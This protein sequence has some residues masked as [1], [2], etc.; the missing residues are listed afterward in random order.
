MKS[1]SILKSKQS[2]KF[3]ISAKR[4]IYLFL[5]FFA[6]ISFLFT[7]NSFAQTTTGG[8][9]GAFSTESAGFGGL[10]SETGQ[11]NAG[12]DSGNAAGGGGGGAGISGGSGGYSGAGNLIVGGTGGAAYGGS[13][14]NGAPCNPGAGECN[15]QGGGGGGGGGAGL[16][17][18]AVTTV[19][20]GT[21]QGGNG[22]S[23]GYTENTA[24][25]VGGGGG[26]GGAGGFGLIA[27]SSAVTNSGSI[28]GGTG[29]A[30]GGTIGTSN[31]GNG[32]S[33]GDGG[34][35]VYLSGSSSLNNSGTITGGAGGAQGVAAGTGIN[36]ASGRIGYGVY[37]SSNASVG[38][39]TNSGSIASNSYA[40][41]TGTNAYVGEISNTSSGTIGNGTGSAIGIFTNSVVGSLNNAGTIDGSF[42][43]WVEG[44][45]TISNL[46]NTGII[47][48]YYG[49]STD[50]G[51][52]IS[53]LTNG[54]SSNSTA[55]ISA[56]YVG[57]LIGTLNNYAVIGGASDG[58]ISVYAGGS[59]NVLN[60]YSTGVIQGY[61]G[62]AAI[63]IGGAFGDPSTTGTIATIN[64]QG[65]I[66]GG[67]NATGIVIESLGNLGALNNLSGGIIQGNRADGLENYGTIANL[68]NAGLIRSFGS[69]GRYGVVNSGT[70][71]YLNNSGGGTIRGLNIGL[72]NNAGGS[73]ATLLNASGASIE[74]AIGLSNAGN[75]GALTNLGEITGSSVASF[76]GIYNTGTITTLNNSQASLIYSGT[77][78]TNYN[79]IINSISSFGKLAVTSASGSTSFGIYSGSTLAKSTYSS[80][81]SGVTSS[82]LTGAK[83]GNYNGFTWSLS[84]SSGTIWDLIV[85]GASTA[86]TQ[87]S[88]VN[89]SQ[90]LQGAYALQNSVLANSFSY[91]CNVFGANNVCVSAG[92]RNT[93]VQAAN[94]LNNTS[95]LLIAAYRL[96]PNYRIGAYADQNLSV[97][98]PGGTVNLGNNT[99]LIGLFGAWNQRLDGTGAEVKVSAAYGQKSATVTRAAVV[100]S[101]PGSGSSNLV[102]QGAQITAKYGFRIKNNV[103]VS[104]Y[105]GVRYTQNNMGGYT[106]GTSSSV[107]A[108][109]TYSALNTNATTALAGVGGSYRVIPAVTTFASAGVETDT[110][111][112]NGT[113]SATGITGLTPINFNANPVK[114][115]PTATLGA[116]YDIE[117]NQRFGVTGIYRQEAY[118]AVS[119]TTVMAT[120]TIGL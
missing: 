15:G 71:T 9:G 41:T 104:P 91:D 69:G 44:N 2:N 90:A 43:I 111:T 28:S 86:D 10:D 96:N 3:S 13:G 6:A 107:T 94:G 73:I 8:N 75:I 84:N 25:G 80:V 59:V 61:S 101:E 113:Y 106:E 56:I 45:S 1:L 7:G 117:K 64:N 116:Y 95:A 32:G 39:I 99:P 81:L 42:A 18:N 68:N 105:V 60:N 112:S 102:S 11:G 31:G 85:T 29:G 46:V 120:Y 74:G 63:D 88:L 66:K 35:G 100:T 27:T 12:G 17:S 67:T 65:L 14:G 93:Q 53:N 5:S 109:L 55:S 37:I 110:N 87:Q 92:G 38:T 118:Q 89:T 19:N 79:I 21:L 103:I 50:N 47:T 49:I 114:T 54:S 108:P 30:G 40:I 77:L 22:G 51:G 82:N 33:G 23:G 76:T 78:P 4:L 119:T 57:S 34:V 52:N 115:R 70:I 72:I 83:S 62:G 20:N 36:G 97:S 24:S 16:F 98:N 26:G 58:N 48:G